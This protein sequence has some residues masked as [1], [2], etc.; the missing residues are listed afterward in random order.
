MVKKSF[1]KSLNELKILQSFSSELSSAMTIDDVAK[2][3]YDHIIQ[4]L[5]VVKKM[6]EVGAV[7]GGEGSG[8][9]IFPDV[10]YGRDS[11]VGIALILQNLFFGHLVKVKPRAKKVNQLR[12]SRMIVIISRPIKLRIKFF[13]RPVNTELPSPPNTAPTSFIF[14]TTFISPTGL[15]LI[16]TY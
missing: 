9:V 3:I 8:G 13:T 11:L 5:P 2:A 16:Q 10:H 12:I 4:L 6:K 7:I 1:K 15:L 14:L